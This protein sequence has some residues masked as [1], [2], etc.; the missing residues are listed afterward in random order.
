MKILVSC[1]PFDGGKSGISVYMRQQVAALAA[2]G[3]ELT[4]IVEAD[5]VQFFSGYR[6]IVLPKWTRRAVFSMLYHLFVLPFRIKWREFDF[7]VIAAANRRA[8]CRYPLFTVA[9]VHDLSQYHVAAK[10]DAFRMFYI[11]RLL[12]F[13]VRK[14]QVVM[15]ISR[16]TAADVTAYWGIPAERVSVVYNGLS[17]SGQANPA[18]DWRSRLGLQRPYLLYI[19]RLE[20]PGKNHVALIRA[21][22]ALP[23]EL[24][25]SVDLVLPGAAWN[26]AEE[27]YAAAK[28]SPYAEHIHFPG[29]V[30]S[31]DMPEAYEEARGYVFPSFFEGFGLS[32]IEAMH[33]GV[34]CACS[35]TSSLGEIGEGAALLFDPD[36]VDEL[37]A[38]LETLLTDEAERARL[39][40]AGKKRAAEFTWENNAAGVCELYRSRR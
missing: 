1:V 11:K 6:L 8:F 4:L 35:R 14:A 22:S 29:F 32:L 15:A 10:Y 38:A 26:G 17:L 28:A 3:H 13:F 12:P 21:Y 27:V 31:E 24:A 5:A 19:S 7:C 33:Y 18:R 23:K 20:H 37:R 39:V 34:P 9:V 36:S 40:A 25:E 16:S 30:A 2:A